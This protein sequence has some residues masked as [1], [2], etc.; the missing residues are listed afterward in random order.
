M[1]CPC[2]GHHQFTIPTLREIEKHYILSLLKLNR[3][4]VLQTARMLG[5]SR[6]T[7]YRKLALYKAEEVGK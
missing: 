3:N 2:C 4:D 5:V 6:T 7:I 1:I